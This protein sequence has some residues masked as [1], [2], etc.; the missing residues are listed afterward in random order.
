MVDN[1]KESFND[2]LDVGKDVVN[3]LE[4]LFRGLGRVIRGDLVGAWREFND[5]G[6]ASIG[7]LETLGDVTLIPGTG[8]MPSFEERMQSDI[9]DAFGRSGGGTTNIEQNNSINIRTTDPERAGRSA[10]N[11]LQRQQDDAQTQSNRGGR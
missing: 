7:L 5:S 11:E 9:R 4:S 10:A 1:F 3:S 6:K 8:D 2:I